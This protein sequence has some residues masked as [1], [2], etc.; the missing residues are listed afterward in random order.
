[1]LGIACP[2]PRIVSPER[3]TNR[4]TRADCI[5]RHGIIPLTGILVSGQHPIR[6]E[7]RKIRIRRQGTDRNLPCA[8]EIERKYD[9]FTIIM[10]LMKWLWLYKVQTV[11]ASGI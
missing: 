9:I 10:F 6:R 4:M 11:C 3:H 2:E 1:M 8:R 7:T 5:N